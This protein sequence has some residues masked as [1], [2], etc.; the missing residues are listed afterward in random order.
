ML[1]S[2]SKHC[3]FPTSLFGQIILNNRYNTRQI[4]KISQAYNNAI[5]KSDLHLCYEICNDK[6]NIVFYLKYCLSPRVGVTI[7]SLCIGTI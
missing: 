5:G 3:E 4:Y 1:L 2:S 7:L 6:I